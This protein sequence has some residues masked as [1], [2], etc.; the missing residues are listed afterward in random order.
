MMETTKTKPQDYIYQPTAFN[1][2]AYLLWIFP[3]P[4]LFIKTL[5][6]DGSSWLPS[7]T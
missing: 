4:Y 7:L 3:N 6:P 5:N 2:V 1:Q